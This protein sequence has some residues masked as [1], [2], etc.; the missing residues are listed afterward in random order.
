MIFEDVCIVLTLFMSNWSVTEATW[1]DW[2]RNV[3]F[4]KFHHHTSFPLWF[5][6]KWHCCCCLTRF[7]LYYLQQNHFTVPNWFTSHIVTLYWMTMRLCIS[8]S[9]LKCSTSAQSLLV[10]TMKK[11]KIM[12]KKK[13]FE[14][15]SIR[16]NL[17]FAITTIFHFISRLLLLHYYS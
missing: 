14:W 13:V 12:K 9:L 11:K 5:E 10:W 2:W 15:W 17:T 7:T 3:F 1:F 6:K 16:T 4:G 8:R